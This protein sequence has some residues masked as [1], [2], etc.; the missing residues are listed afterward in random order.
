MSNKHRKTI[1]QIYYYTVVDM[2]RTAHEYEIV[3]NSKK[4]GINKVIEQALIDDVDIYR[5]NFEFC[6]PQ[7]AIQ[8]RLG[9]NIAQT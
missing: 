2:E 9:G 4:S 1:T 3:A 7:F 6:E 8:P 5:I